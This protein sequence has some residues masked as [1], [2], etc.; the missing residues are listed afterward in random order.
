MQENPVADRLST[1]PNGE[2]K[3]KR[4]KLVLCILAA[5]SMA[6]AVVACNTFEGMGRDIESLGRKLSGN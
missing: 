1:G 2:T 3:M 4:L 6:F 5:L